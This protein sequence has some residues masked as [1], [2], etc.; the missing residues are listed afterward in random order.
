MTLIQSIILGIVQGLTEFIPVS[1]SGHLV[2]VPHI[3]GWR[4][5]ED[6]VFIFDVFVQLGTLLAL[7]VYFQKD[8]C[9][10]VKGIFTGIQTKVLFKGEQSRLVGLILLSTIPAGIFGY[11]IKYL[12][13]S[14]FESPKGTSLF[15]LATASLL[16]IAEWIGK[17]MRA[18]EDITWIDALWIGCFQVLA[19]FPGI[20]RSGATIAGGM[21]RNLR[22]PAAARYSFLMA[23]PIMIAAGF[24]ATLDLIRLPNFSAYLLPLLFGCITSALVGYLAIHWLLKYLTRHPL[25]MFALYCGVLGLIGIF[26][27]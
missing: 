21:T 13:V 17:R 4:L 3:F 19:L 18:I 11:F 26:V 6:L 5:E 20:S 16:L 1:S 7:I 25:Y 10:M 8:L 9:E 24:L 15:L 23:I 22:R 27:F 2:L 12:V 14:A